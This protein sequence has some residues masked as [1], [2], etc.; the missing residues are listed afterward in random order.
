V[1]SFVVIWW[2]VYY[3]IYYSL[4]FAQCFHCYYTFLIVTLYP[5]YLT[6]TII[7]VTNT[8]IVMHPHNIWHCTFPLQHLK[9]YIMTTYPEVRRVDK[10]FWFISHA[11]PVVLM[12]VYREFHNIIKS[13]CSIL[14]SDL[15]LVT[16][17]QS[18]IAAGNWL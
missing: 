17:L 10:R 11:L 5:Y 18:T 12:Y 9:I 1:S 14:S 8:I 3:T 2:D 7:S 6:M 13:P 15:K 4:F 16:V